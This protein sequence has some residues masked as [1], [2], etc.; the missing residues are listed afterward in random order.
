MSEALLYCT[1]HRS[2]HMSGKQ[3]STHQS[4]ISLAENATLVDKDIVGDGAT[5]GWSDE[6]EALLV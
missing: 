2:E 1:I 6:P 5:L 4:A 3:L